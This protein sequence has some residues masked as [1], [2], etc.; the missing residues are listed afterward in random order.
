MLSQLDVKTHETFNVLDM[1][2]L[3]KTFAIAFSGGKDSTLLSILFYKWLLHRGVHG[4][5]VVFIHNDTQSEFDVLENYARSFLNKICDLIRQ[6]GNECE[7][8]ITKPYSHSFYWKVIVAGYPAPSV[9]FRWCQNH[10]KIKPTKLAM[11]SLVK[12]YGNIVLLTG[13]R[14]DES[15][16]RSTA[17]KHNMACDTAQSCTSSFMLKTDMAKVKKVMPLL[18]W[19]LDEVWTYLD[20]VRDEYGLDGLYEVYGGNKEVR[21]GCWH[22]TL[23]KVPKNVYV[24]PER[25][26]YLEGARI[27]YRAVSDLE[28]VRTVKYWGRTKLGP[29]NEV[30]RGIMLKLFRA[31]EELSKVRLYGLDEDTIEGHTLREVF[32]EMEPSQADSLILRSARQAKLMDIATRVIPIE[33]IRNAKVDRTI[34]EKVENIAKQNIAYKVLSL[35]G[36]Q[37]IDDLLA[38]IF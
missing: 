19:K 28:E 37:Y 25:Y 27:I 34:K 36:S 38:L 29:L 1:M 30:G 32:Y 26:Y 13:H 5:K 31:V 35:K 21:Y 15:I 17:I 33:K 14:S 10:L 11:D 18:N 16:A 12:K 2:K 7:I 9:M 3:E 20:S 4:K 6:T 24:L 23:V 22:C 8:V